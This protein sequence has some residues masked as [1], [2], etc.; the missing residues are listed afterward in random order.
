MIKKCLTYNS[1]AKTLMITHFSIKECISMLQIRQE[2]IK[3]NFPY[4]VK[5]TFSKIFVPISKTK[6]AHEKKVKEACT[7]NQLAVMLLLLSKI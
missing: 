2:R 3:N 5:V 1:H 4:H 6:I 7:E